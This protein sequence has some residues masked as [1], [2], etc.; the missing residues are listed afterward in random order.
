M[1]G[2]VAASTEHANSRDVSS[3]MERTIKLNPDAV[4][5]AEFVVSRTLEDGGQTIQGVADEMAK[6]SE[7]LPREVLDALDGPGSAMKFALTYYQQTLVGALALAKNGEMLSPY[8][9]HALA[10]AAEFAR[11]AF[12]RE[13]RSAGGEDEAINEKIQ[14]CELAAEQLNGHLPAG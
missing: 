14:R 10:G 12:Q 5:L 4:E 7:R 2:G 13:L 11:S 6:K 9:V 3:K 8:Q 1:T